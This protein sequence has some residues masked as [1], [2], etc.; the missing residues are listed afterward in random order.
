MY[1][2]ATQLIRY[3]LRT[4][5][6]FGIEDADIPKLR[7]SD[8]DIASR[9]QHTPMLRIIYD[10]QAPPLI[11]TDYSSGTPVSLALAEQYYSRRQAER[12][13]LGAILREG[14]Y[15]DQAD[16]ALLPRVMGR[17][18]EENLWAVKVVK[19]NRRCMLAEWHA[20]AQANSKL[21]RCALV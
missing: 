7:E 5:V 12:A 20:A 2:I 1:Y 3:A 4:A 17:L 16:T 21:L 18:D 9:H 10:D 8:R 15:W 13:V 19:A 11:S 6:S 14:Q